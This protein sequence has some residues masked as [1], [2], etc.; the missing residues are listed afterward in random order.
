MRVAS[1][2]ALSVGALGRLGGAT[3]L[4]TSRDGA[5]GDRRI[6]NSERRRLS[7]G[8]GASTSST[9]AGASCGGSGGLNL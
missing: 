4:V 1:G 6:A 5:H 7:A 9:I 3:Y 2:L 8:I